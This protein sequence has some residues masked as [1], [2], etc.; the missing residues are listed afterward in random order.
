MLTASSA[1]RA[2]K[3]KN[4]RGC[5]PQTRFSYRLVRHFMAKHSL[6]AN[7]A[8]WSKESRQSY[9]VSYTEEY[10]DIQYFCWRCGKP[11]VFTAADQKHSAEVKKNY[12]W[13][14]R[15]LCQGCWT[16]A[17]TIRKALGTC[18]AQWRDAK[19]SL[20]KD[21]S[22]LSHWLK[23]LTKLEEYVPYRPDTAKKNMLIKLIQQNA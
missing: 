11:D 9:A 12:I 16:D 3:P 10:V 6:K 20:Q 19:A 18:Q 7:P 23:L 5:A 15:I 21:V 2:R 8:K 1:Q 13:Q 4:V 17:N 22:F 14:R